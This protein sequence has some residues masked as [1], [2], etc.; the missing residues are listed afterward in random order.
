MEFESRESLGDGITIRLVVHPLVQDYE[1][2]SVGHIANE[3]PKSLLH[4]TDAVRQRVF[5]EPTPASL[6]DSPAFRSHKRIG[7]DWEGEFD[8]EKALKFQPD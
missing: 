4:F 1:Q 6:L 5:V 3:S 7:R 8:D 2:P